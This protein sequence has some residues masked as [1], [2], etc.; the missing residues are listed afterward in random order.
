MRI[1][2]QSANTAFHRAISTEKI[3]PDESYNI[4]VEQRK[5]RPTSPHLT[6][7]RPQITWVGSGLNRVTGVIVSGVFYVWGLGYLASP[8][9]GLNLGS[10]SLAAGF[11]AWPVAAKIAAK[12][13]LALPFTYHCINGLRHLVWD[14]GRHFNNK[15]IIRSGWAAVTATVLSTIYLVGFV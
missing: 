4:L 14:T 5:K 12:A 11:A 15:M 2:A 8:L 10:A 1:R 13:T 6:I 9:L 7:Y 3:T